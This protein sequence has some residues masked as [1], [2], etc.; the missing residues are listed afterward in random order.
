MT[1]ALRADRDTD[2]GIATGRIYANCL[3]AH[4]GAGAS[5]ATGFTPTQLKNRIISAQ[6]ATLVRL[7]PDN[8]LRLG[9]EYRNNRLDGV[10]LYSPQIDYGVWSGSGILDLHPT[11]ILA[12]TF[13]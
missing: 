12:L 10:A 8:V 6:G 3:D 11:D 1:A 13:A 2:W 4:F 9:V 5:G 7:A